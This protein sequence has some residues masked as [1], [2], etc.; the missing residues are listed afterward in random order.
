MSAPEEKTGCCDGDIGGQLG[1]DDTRK[2]G[3]R[4]LC[5]NAGGKEL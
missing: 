3:K 4:R 5:L 1:R 2:T